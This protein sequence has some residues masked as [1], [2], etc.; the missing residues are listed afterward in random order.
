MLGMHPLLSKAVLP[1]VGVW[2]AEDWDDLVDMNAP[3]LFERIVVADRGAAIRG[4]SRWDERWVPGTPQDEKE[5]ERN[6]RAE[7]DDG[8]PAWA[9]PFVG[10]ETVY[11]SGGSGSG[12]EGT[13]MAW[14]AP[15][16]SALLRF[17]HLEEDV[18]EQRKDS[19]FGIGGWGRKSGQG[20][21][22]RNGA[23]P[24]LTYISTQDES[25]GVVPRLNDEDHTRLV[26][27][28]E[29]LERKGV[30]GAVHVVK[31]NGSVGGHGWEWEAR[32]RAIAKSSVS[33]NKCGHLVHMHMPSP[34]IPDIFVLVYFFSPLLSRLSSVRMVI[35]WPTASS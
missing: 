3:W 10:L 28:L 32:M 33:P 2:Y 1:T 30:L 14:W 18:P 4:R 21:R 13:T 15:V 24:V 25:A 35:T 7:V 6:A 16:R 31:G 22:S 11:G 5:K 34:E 9:A 26:E 8:K 20:G 27:R 17:L 19:G 23:K 12:S 29:G